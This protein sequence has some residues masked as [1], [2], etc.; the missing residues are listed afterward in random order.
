MSKCVSDEKGRRGVAL[1]CGYDLLGRTRCCGIQGDKMMRDGMITTRYR[2]LANK[3]M[4]SE[5]D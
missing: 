4:A 5:A 3:D 2:R 1:A